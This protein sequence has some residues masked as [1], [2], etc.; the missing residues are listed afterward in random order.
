MKGWTVALLVHFVPFGKAA[1]DTCRYMPWP[2]RRTGAAGELCRPLGHSHV[3][4]GFDWQKVLSSPVLTPL[5]MLIFTFSVYF[6][7]CENTVKNFTRIFFFF[8]FGRELVNS[9]PLLPCCYAP[10]MCWFAL[11][12]LQIPVSTFRLKKNTTAGKFSSQEYIYRQKYRKKCSNVHSHV[13]PWAGNENYW[14]KAFRRHSQK[15]RWGQESHE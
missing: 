6:P 13:R 9:W 11:W 3:C 5:V 10:A 8:F 7:H 14:L 4:S 12:K 1:A 15:Q 2:V